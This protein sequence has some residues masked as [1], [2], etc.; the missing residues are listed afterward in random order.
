MRKNRLSL[1]LVLCLLSAT[2]AK[3]QDHVLSILSASGNP[4]SIVTISNIY[5]NNSSTDNIGGYTWGNRIANPAIADILTVNL[6]AD[7]G[8]PG[9]PLPAFF[10]AELFPGEGWTIAAVTSAL[11]M[12]P[13]PPGSTLNVLAVADYMVTGVGNTSIDYCG[14]LGSP[15]VEPEVFENNSANSLVPLQNS[16]VITGLSLNFLTVETVTG[17]VGTSVDAS[18]S[19]T[20]VL[21]I[22]GVQ[23]ALTYDDSLVTFLGATTEGPASGSDFFEANASLTGELT[24]GIVR[25]LDG[26]LGPAAIPPGVH[27]TIVT[28]SWDIP[29]GTPALTSSPLTLSDGLGRPIIDN[30]IFFADSTSEAPNLESGAINIIELN[31]FLRGNCNGAGN[32]INIADGIFL[33]NFLFQMGPEPSCGDACDVNDDAML[34]A[35]DAIYIFNFQFVEGAPPPFAPFPDIGIDLTPGDGLGCNGDVDDL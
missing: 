4:G 6:G 8:G 11:S 30:L 10:R 28:T 5:D 24:I 20:N 27:V 23:I 17:A 25:D 22:T 26:T 2:V 15:L 16:G 1:A 13:I 3:G 9:N 33:L 21:D 35:S 12:S 14:S 7:S 18:I 31:P 32:N 19:L 29:A 34:D